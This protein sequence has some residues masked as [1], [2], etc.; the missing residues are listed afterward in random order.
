[1][2]VFLTFLQ[3]F[4]GGRSS[5]HGCQLSEARITV[6]LSPTAPVRNQ[7]QILKILETFRGRFGKPARCIFCVTQEDSRILAESGGYLRFSILAFHLTNAT[8]IDFSRSGEPEVGP[9]PSCSDGPTSANGTR[10]VFFCEIC[11]AFW[12]AITDHS[13]CIEWYSATAVNRTAANG[14]IFG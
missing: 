11:K 6:R 9:F 7:P 8:L 4:T 10:R 13:I 5:A 3:Y 12:Q 1:M 14:R 2:Y